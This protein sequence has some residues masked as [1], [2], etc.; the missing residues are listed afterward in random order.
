MKKRTI[1]K[2]WI[3]LFVL[4]L[5]LPLPVIDFVDEIPSH[6]I[7][8]RVLKEGYRVIGTYQRSTNEI[9]ILKQEPHI[10][11]TTFHE[12]VHWQIFKLHLPYKVHAWFDN[13]DFI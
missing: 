7:E 6:I 2:I 9:H 11:K 4:K 5:L 3:F 13:L 8:H 1:A 10:V 12:L